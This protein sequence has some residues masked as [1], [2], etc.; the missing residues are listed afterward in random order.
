MKAILALALLGVM[1]VTCHAETFTVKFEEL[2]TDNMPRSA[3]VGKL[4]VTLY[5]WGNKKL[6]RT[7]PRVV[8]RYG[9][10]GVSTVDVTV[11]GKANVD[12]SRVVLVWVG[13]QE[14]VEEGK[15]LEICASKVIVSRGRESP[16]FYEGGCVEDGD[17]VTLKHVS[18]KYKTLVVEIEGWTG[19]KGELHLAL[20]K[21]DKRWTS[22]VGGARPVH[23]KGW[24]SEK[25]VLT[26]RVTVQ[27][28]VHEVTHVNLEWVGSNSSEKVCISGVTV[29]DPK[30]PG[31]RYV[32]PGGCGK[33][34]ERIHDKFYYNFRLERESSDNN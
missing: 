1:A 10:N 7:S 5:D 11:D 27:V 19:G 23:W 12:V 4:Y 25:R 14:E 18:E 33:Y 2:G 28:D 34:K 9:E 17:F 20:I 31:S 15:S 22:F 24:D 26:Q 6:G 16:L 32:F 30:I 3:V 13:S 21:E 8:Q 29:S